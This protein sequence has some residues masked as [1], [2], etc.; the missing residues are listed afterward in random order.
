M[1]AKDSCCPSCSAC[2][3]AFVTVVVVFD[4]YQG[5]NYLIGWPSS[6]SKSHSGMIDGR[7]FR[8]VPDAMCPEDRGLAEKANWL[9]VICCCRSASSSHHLRRLQRQAAPTRGAG[10]AICYRQSCG[11][12]RHCCTWLALKHK[13]PQ[14]GARLTARTF[15]AKIKLQVLHIRGRQ[16][17]LSICSSVRN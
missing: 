6:V 3:F 14:P 8:L 13:L 9:R 7:T 1:V 15:P 17:C 2:S 12:W 11:S 10:D 5:K 16:A 4:F